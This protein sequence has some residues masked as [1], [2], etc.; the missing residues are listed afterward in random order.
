MCKLFGR[1]QEL[2]RDAATILC[3]CALYAVYPWHSCAGNCVLK[4]ESSRRRRVVI[5][6]FVI[7]TCVSAFGEV[8]LDCPF[9]CIH[10]STMQW[11]KNTNGLQMQPIKA[12][13]Q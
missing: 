8:M 9:L 3:S 13:I 6:Y 7:V 11:S 12:N 4:R 2:K 10:L 1:T 5:V